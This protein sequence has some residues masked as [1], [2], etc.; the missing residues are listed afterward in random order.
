MYLH[1]SQ[2]DSDCTINAAGNLGDSTG[3][4][5]CPPAVLD[6]TPLTFGD[7]GTATTTT[8]ST[9]RAGSGLTLTGSTF[10]RNP[11]AFSELTI[12]PAGLLDGDNDTTYSA[13]TGLT[14]TGTTFS[15]DFTPADARYLRLSGGSLTGAVT[16]NLASGTA[17]TLSTTNTGGSALSVTNNGTFGGSADG[18][19][20]YTFSSGGAA[21]V[22]W[23]K[24]TATTN[25][26]YGVWGRA[27]SATGVA[28]QGVTTPTPGATAVRGDAS[29]QSGT[30]VVGNGATGG[31]FQSTTTGGMAV[32]A[33]GDNAIWAN[34]TS[35]GIAVRGRATGTTAIGVYGE[36]VGSSGIAVQAV[37]SAGGGNAI[38]A[39]LS[40]GITN[41]TTTTDNLF[42]GQNLGTNVARVDR[43]GRGFFNGGTQTNGADVAESMPADSAFRPLEPG[44]V[45]VVS[46]VNDGHVALSCESES[47]TVLGV[48]STRPGVILTLHDVA[49]ESV[50]A[51]EVP[52]GIKG[53]IPTK[54][55]DEGGA[56][57]RGDLLVTASRAGYAKRASANPKPGSIV[58]K[59]LAE[60]ESGEALILVMVSVQ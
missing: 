59:A 35:G 17:L 7:S 22:G 36:T 58:G 8:R 31:S 20:A 26:N 45:L 25:S 38:V 50:P 39:N 53:R 18:I 30:G 29:S 9:Y 47:T 56:I 32:F 52:C 16:S 1:L 12:I 33:Q 27:D 48:Y 57:H 37:T 44:D 21:I 4:T 60:L 11:V 40:T 5:G 10:S 3:L 42:I 41:S 49:G 54:V 28:V 43:T 51:G 14:L 6:S 34:G 2:R 46:R 19:D 23:S 15:I 55:C 24:T 13:G